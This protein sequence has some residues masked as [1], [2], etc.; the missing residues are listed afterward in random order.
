MYRILD[1]DNCIAD[2]AWR[3]PKID[4]RLPLSM[5]RYTAYHNA[6]IYDQPAN[7]HL[8][9]HPRI[10]ICTG[11]PVFV[12]GLTEEWLRMHGVRYEH[13]LMRNNNDVRRSVDVKREHIR[14]LDNTYDIPTGAISSA[15]DDHPDIV[16]MYLTLGI[17]ASLTSI[18]PFETVY[19]GQSS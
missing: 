8:I 16:D 15:H 14:W 7:L 19:A 2:D 6:C 5:E 18:R 3:V 10:I 4:K 13:L 12:R 9:D 17:P 11:R 1:L